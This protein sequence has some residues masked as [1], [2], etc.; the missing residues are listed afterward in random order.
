[1]KKSFSLPALGLLCVFGFSS[2]ACAGESIFAYTYTTDIQP[3][4]R[5]E[6]EHQSTARFQKEHGDYTVLDSREEIEYGIADNFQIALYLNHHYAYAN[7]DVP[8]EDPSNPGHR[9]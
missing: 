9:L 3:K 2:L 8:V 4:G 5:W 1:M 6:Y 7:N